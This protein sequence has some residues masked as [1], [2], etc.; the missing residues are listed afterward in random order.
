MRIVNNV[1]VAGKVKCEYK[2]EFCPFLKYYISDN[3]YHCLRF[4]DTLGA[5]NKR[6]GACKIKHGDGILVK[7]DDI[8]G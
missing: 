7:I 6:T 2:G 4:G 8:Q 5:D 3:Q 1:K